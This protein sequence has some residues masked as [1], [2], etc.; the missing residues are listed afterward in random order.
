[1][2]DNGM[3]LVQQ[4][5]ALT[6]NARQ[7]LNALIRS[8]MQSGSSNGYT[9]KRGDTEL[10]LDRNAIYKLYDFYQRW[11]KESFDQDVFERLLQECDDMWDRG[12]RAVTKAV[13]THAQICFL[14]SSDK[15]ISTADM[16][17]ASIDELMVWCNKVKTVN[18]KKG[19]VNSAPIPLNLRTPLYDENLSTKSFSQFETYLFPMEYHVANVLGTIGDGEDHY[20][21]GEN[22]IIEAD[23]AIKL[24][25]QHVV[26]GDIP[27]GDAVPP[28]KRKNYGTSAFNLSAG[29]NSYAFGDY[30]VALNNYNIAYGKN[31]FAIGDHNIAYGDN[32]MAGGTYSYAA[33]GH[34]LAFGNHAIAA[35][36]GSMA[37]GAFAY[38]GDMV[39]EFKLSTKDNKY[40]T[41][42]CTTVVNENGE[43]VKREKTSVDTI[44]GL[45]IQQS[46]QLRLAEKDMVRIFYQIRTAESNEQL[47]MDD[48]GYVYTEML[49]TVTKITGPAAD[50]YFIELDKAIPVEENGI[51]TVVGGYITR[52]KV[53]INELNLLTAAITGT[54]KTIFPGKNS[55]A[56]NSYVYAAG[57]NQTVVGAWNFGNFDAR[58]IVGTGDTGMGGRLA[59]GLV[60][61]PQYGI[62]STGYVAVTV[63]DG[64]GLWIT[65]K[66]R[67]TYTDMCNGAA[68]NANWDMANGESFYDHRSVVNAFR[69]GAVMVHSQNERGEQ[70]KWQSKIA[71]GGTGKR[72][73]TIEDDIDITAAVESYYG[74]VVISSGPRSYINASGEDMSFTKY[75]VTRS[76]GLLHT[77]LRGSSADGNMGI[78]AQNMLEI[79][80]RNEEGTS[81]I[82]INSCGYLRATF[83]TLTLNGDTY[84]TLA[85]TSDSRSHDMRYFEITPYD[86]GTHP[87]YSGFYHTTG[88][89]F[90]DLIGKK[91]VMGNAHVIASASPYGVDANGKMMYSTAGLVLPDADNAE[92]PEVRAMVWTYGSDQVNRCNALAYY[93]DVLKLEEEN[94]RLAV[95]EKYPLG[96]AGI[97]FPV[98]AES[99]YGAN[100]AKRGTLSKDATIKIVSNSVHYVPQNE[101]FYSMPAKITYFNSDPIYDKLFVYSTENPDP[102][103]YVGGYSSGLALCRDTNNDG[104]FDG[105]LKLVVGDFWSSMVGPYLNMSFQ[106]SFAYNHISEISFYLFL[107]GATYSYDPRYTHGFYKTE[108][109]TDS[110]TGAEFEITLIPSMPGAMHVR[111]KISE[112][113][114]E[115]TRGTM[116]ITNMFT[117]LTATYDDGTNYN[118]SVIVAGKKELDARI[119]S[120]QYGG[121]LMS[122]VDL[123]LL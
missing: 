50:G 114:T 41:S 116:T 59:N 122:L 21:G 65:K 47:P 89:F 7:V 53:E 85:A 14:K 40:T 56:L 5:D 106:Y 123:T 60:I 61:A 10:V 57:E 71:V 78:Y 101:S 28:V 92:N 115:V 6:Y 32:S 73:S 31:S 37:V 62:M 19:T 26:I 11:E 104:S 68:L 20:A 2:I 36:V 105:A 30:A 4:I 39:Y 76:D 67:D 117:P 12:G 3:K 29:H 54:K 119:A 35:G 74:T 87:R 34:S 82:S 110:K 79:A 23:T 90:E 18:N 25:G 112:F 38:A 77:A 99:D 95:L 72:M 75:M 113:K 93:S 45:T 51:A 33:D 100:Y 52:Y 55:V 22:W 121:K 9:V 80:A 16:D 83:E 27:S 84:G 96:P 103:Q 42:D 81:V 109:Y 66:Y 86:T 102:K 97:V 94:K 108:T 118:T 70:S 107:G 69:G 58:F 64:D 111:M 91:G 49:A 8:C 15:G 120:K 17:S 46:G 43:C 88:G 13:A 1:M 98:L 44:R 63:S 24:S 48:N